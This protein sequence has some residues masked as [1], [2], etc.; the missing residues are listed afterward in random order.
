MYY[1]IQNMMTLF[2]RRMAINGTM[3]LTSIL[4]LSAKTGENL[5]DRY[6]FYKDGVAFNDDLR[7]KFI[8]DILKSLG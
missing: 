6:L 7:A 1:L 5:L 2:K 4:R 3:C 8:S